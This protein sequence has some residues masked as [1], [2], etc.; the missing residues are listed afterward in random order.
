[1]L[2]GMTQKMDGQK[3]R[4]EALFFLGFFRTHL[5]QIPLY[6]KLNKFINKEALYDFN[7]RCKYH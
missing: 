6:A 3:N 7:R 5:K 4:A 2:A 1:M